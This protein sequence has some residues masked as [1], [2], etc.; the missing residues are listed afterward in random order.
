MR[1]FKL[2]TV[3]IALLGASVVFGW[4]T[5]ANADGTMQVDG[6]GVPGAPGAAPCDDAEYADADY[7]IGMTGDLEGCIYGYITDF[8]F[9]PSG[10]YQEYADEIF[11][12]S[13]GSLSGTFELKEF[14]T[15]KY[16][17]EGNQIWG[18]CKHP[19]VEGSGTGD[20]A[21]LTG[22][23]DFKDDIEA[24]NAPYKGHLDFG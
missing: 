13:Y 16:D 15:A 9:H 5:P 11:V 14:F 23:L 7:V 4:A 12:G 8:R 6:V 18:R 21:G 2:I 3:V 22:R 24:R 19:V 10:T 20:F 17:D 1:K